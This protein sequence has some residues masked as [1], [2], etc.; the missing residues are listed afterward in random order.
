MSD[1]IIDGWA[2]LELMGHRRLAGHLSEVQIGGASFIRIDVPADLPGDDPASVP[3]GA[4]QIYSPAA[5]YCV[6]PCDEDT[7]RKVA[8]LN[9]PA[10]VHRWELPAAP[11]PDSPPGEDD[12][13]D[14][15][16]LAD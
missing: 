16:Q 3:F 4:T 5:I 10:P 11:G 9:R 13:A 15:Y 7:A 1:S 6:T 8:T 14:Q 12:F 2:I